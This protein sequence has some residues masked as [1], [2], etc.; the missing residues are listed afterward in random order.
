MTTRGFSGRRPSDDI[1]RRLPPGQYETK[2][3][4]V[5]AKDR[6]RVSIKQPGNLLSTKDRGF[7]R[8][9][10]GM[11]SKPYPGQPGAATSIA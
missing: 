7:S 4:P 11:S 9:G 2:D 6:L 1:A 10:L 3:F 5:L 8:T